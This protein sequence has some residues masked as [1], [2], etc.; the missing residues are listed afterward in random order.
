MSEYTQRIASLIKAHPLHIDTTVQL[1]GRVPTS[2]SSEF[3]TNKAQ[4]DW[5]ESLVLSSLNESKEYAAFPYGRSEAIAAG[6]PG[7]AYFYKQYLAELNTIGKRPDILVFRKADVPRGTT[8]DFEDEN[9]IRKAVAAIE[10]RSSSFLCTEYA[11][12]MEQRNLE[13]ENECRLL[14]SEIL[15]EPYGSLLH[16]KAPALHTLLQSYSAQSFKDLDFR[17]S[18][19]KKSPAL[20]HLSSLL[21]NLKQNIRSLR[22]RDFLSITPKVEDIALV[23]RWIQQF[24]VPHFYLQVFFDQGYIIPFE[25]ILEI[26]SNPS[27]EDTLFSVEKDVKNQEKTTIKINIEA[28]Q[29][30]LQKI[31]LH[32]HYSIQKKLDRGRLL[33][34]VKFSGGDC[35]FN[36]NILHNL[37]EQ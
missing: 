21:P 28:A 10:V 20:L 30:I 15:S 8:L 32:E 11:S 33:F 6:D 9:L 35:I 22:K 12:Y 37:L 2:V 36:F 1:A 18:H 4:G 16:S 17:L 14:R 19:W 26:S 24:Q 27:L 3:L 5:A 25:K 13:I 29:K 31:S 23:N 7:F 34:Y